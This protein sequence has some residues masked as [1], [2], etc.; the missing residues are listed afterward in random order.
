MTAATQP[1]IACPKCGGQMW[2]N[3]ASKKN[4]KAP[5]FKCRARSC[6]GVRWP[7]RQS[8]PQRVQ[9]PAVAAIGP[10]YGNLP[11]V[12]MENAAP[13]PETGNE[14]LQ[15]IFKVQEVCFKHAV[16][17]AGMVSN[18]LGVPVTLEGLSALTAQTLIA[19]NGRDGR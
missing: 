11:G 13:S 12:P 18:D 14:R 5:D 7:E 16:K 19:F 17:L 15:R 6:D 10:E 1:L 4:P 9:T 8:G 3:R 2:D